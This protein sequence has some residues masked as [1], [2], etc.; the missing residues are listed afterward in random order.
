MDKTTEEKQET[1]EY[2][3]LEQQAMQHG[4]KPKDQFEEVEGKEWRTAKEFMDR[5]SLFDKI[6]A[7]KNERKRLERD[8][9]RLAEHNA[10]IEKI[11]YEKALRELKQERAKAL[12]DGD[13]KRAEELRDE[14]DEVKQKA[15]NVIV[16]QVNTVPDE[17][18]RWQAENSWYQKDEVMTLYADG[19][20]NRLRD[21][22][23]HPSDILREVEKNVRNK[24]PEK[25]RN[26]SKDTA[27]VVGQSGKKAAARDD[28]K[29]S[30]EDERLISNMIKAG[31]P[32][33]REK[34]IEQLKEIKSIRG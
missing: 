23:V 27:P 21:Q 1:V 25:F 12:E 32:I 24:F 16:P 7:E 20:G 13:I 34:Y 18:I 9:I 29:L 17:F 31:A 14:M 3:E 30:A 28:F 15:A 4:W 2:T 26:P 11:A 22:G 33:T 5:K 19:L 8:V 6:E 10:K